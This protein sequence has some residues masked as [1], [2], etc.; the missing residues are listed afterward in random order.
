MTRFSVDNPGKQRFC[1]DALA[2]SGWVASEETLLDTSVTCG[3][4]LAGDDAIR[5]MDDESTTPEE[6]AEAHARFRRHVQLMRDLAALTTV[7][8][9]DERKI[10]QVVLD[11]MESL[12]NREWNSGGEAALI[13]EAWRQLG[14]E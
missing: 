5:R 14:E 7:G 6:R 12:R 10:G 13:L 3:F 1:L 11:Y 9:E 8:R 4:G 2:L